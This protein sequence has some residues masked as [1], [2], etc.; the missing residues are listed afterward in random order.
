MPGRALARAAARIRARD[1]SN[2]TAGWVV[3]PGV[4]AT[5]AHPVSKS[6]IICEKPSVARD[7]AAAL[8]GKLAK[9]GDFWEGDEAIVAYAVGHLVEQVD[10]EAYDPRFKKWR[11]DDLPIVPEHFRYEARD[12]RA[13]KQ[14]KSLHR[15]MARKDVDVLVNACDAGREGELIF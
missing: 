10:P 12:A 7:V 11:Y 15:L 3:R 13:E 1:V 2:V 4:G 14:L 6:L 5:L 8:P 9:K